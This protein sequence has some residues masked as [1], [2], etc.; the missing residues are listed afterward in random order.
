M[1]DPVAFAASRYSLEWKVGKGV[2][3]EKATGGKRESI[4]VDRGKRSD[5][6]LNM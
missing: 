4:S 1:T 3:Q 5:D 6:R 2:R